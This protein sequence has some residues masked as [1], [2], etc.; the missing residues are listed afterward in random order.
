MIALAAVQFGMAVLAVSSLSFLGFGA[1]PPTPEWGSLVSEGR[2]F[3]A[4]SW[5]L[6]TLPGLV[7]VAVVLSAHRVGHALDR[8]D[9]A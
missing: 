7:I 4:T 2:N 8:G 6:T 3:L 1:V 9:R 5:W